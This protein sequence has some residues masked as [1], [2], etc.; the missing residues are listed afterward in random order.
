MAYNHR[1][2]LLQSGDYD[3]IDVQGQAPDWAEVL[4]VFAV[5][6]AGADVGGLDIATLDADRVD[7]LTAVF[8]DMTEIG[9]AAPRRWHQR[10]CGD[11]SRNLAWGNHLHGCKNSL[12]PS[13]QRHA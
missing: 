2:E 1:L 9:A 5:R 13:M 6:T 4:A 11:V 3:V 7:K 12:A 10:G 8:W